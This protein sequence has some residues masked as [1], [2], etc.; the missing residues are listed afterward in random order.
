[1][2]NCHNATVVTC[3]IAR[4]RSSWTVRHCSLSVTC[5]GVSY[6]SVDLSR[7]HDRWKSVIIINKKKTWRRG[8]VTRSRDKATLCNKETHITKNTSQR[9]T[10]H[11]HSHYDRKAMN[12][13]IVS[14]VTQ[15]SSTLQA[16]STTIQTAVPIY[17]YILVSVLSAVNAKSYFQYDTIRYICVRSKADAIARL[18]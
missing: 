5:T 2:L 17:Y 10:A 4:W 15:C 13:R 8:H 9:K 6:K 3:D 1:M 14:N 16:E 18:I 12:D 11:G 7:A